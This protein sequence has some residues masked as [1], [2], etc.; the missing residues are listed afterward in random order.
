MQHHRISHATRVFDSGEMMPQ[1]GSEAPKFLVLWSSNHCLVSTSNSNPGRAAAS[2]CPA[3]EVKPPAFPEQV[4]KFRVA[5]STSPM[6]IKLE[7]LGR[8]RLDSEST[9]AND[10]STTPKPGSEASEFSEASMS[11]MT[12][13]EQHVATTPLN[14]TPSSMTP[15][16]ET[17]GSAAAALAEW[18]WSPSTT[19]AGKIAASAPTSPEAAGLGL[20]GK[21]ASGGDRHCSRR[22]VHSASNFSNSCIAW[23]RSW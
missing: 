1:S 15:S 18:H 9:A 5:S 7:L 20:G 12:S 3:K 11:S 22:D 17:K 8:R 2:S 21:G 19:G 14:A 6:V 23:T 16:P 13:S 10:W 4:S